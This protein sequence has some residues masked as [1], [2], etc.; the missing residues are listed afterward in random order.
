[1]GRFFMNFG[2]DHLGVCELHNLFIEVIGQRA[3]LGMVLLEVLGKEDFG[4]F[5]SSFAEQKLAIL[6][7]Q[8]F[9]CGLL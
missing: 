1:M 6:D 7:G 5:V 9:F 8:T 3:I 4:L 2:W